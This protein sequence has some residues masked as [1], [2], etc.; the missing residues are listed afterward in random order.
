MARRSTGRGAAVPP[1][2]VLFDLDD[3]LVDH[4]GAVLGAFRSLRLSYPA[5]ARRRARELAALYQL[6]L[7]RVHAAVVRGRISAE[8]ARL[9]RFAAVFES[10]GES[11]SATQLQRVVA[12]Y[13]AEYRRARRLVPGALGV[14]RAVRREASVGVL[15]NNRRL[16][17]AEKVATFGLGPYLDFVLTS[18]ELPWAK[19]DPRCFRAA[20]ERA[21]SVPWRATMVGDSWSADVAGALAAGLG[22]VWLNREGERPGRARRV[23]QLASLQPVRPAVQTILGALPRARGANHY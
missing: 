18:E 21:G 8:A 4:T 20:V 9:R 13:Q 15:S 19:P 5:L 22:A 23:P 2:V 1:R 3:T 12:T 17:Q 14:L 11:P 16:E 10:V 6:H 7:E